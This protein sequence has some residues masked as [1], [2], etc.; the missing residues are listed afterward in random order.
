MDIWCREYRRHFVRDEATAVSRVPG[1][2]L[3][4]GSTGYIGGRL[5]RRL[6]ADGCAVRCLVRRPERLGSQADDTTEMVQGDLL[7]PETLPEAMRG[8]ST[9]YYLVHSMA[10]AGDYA[11]QDRKAA[12]AFSSAAREAGVGRIVYLGGLGSGAKLSGHLRSRQEVGRILRGSGVPTIE[13]RAS[14]IIGSGSLSFEMI[15]S[16]V[17]KLPVMLT[18]RWVHTMSQPIAVEDVIEYLAAALKIP[19]EKSRIVEI[20]GS[21]RASYADI[22]EAYAR[23]RGLR[24][25]MISVPVLSPRLSGLWLGLIT[26]IYARV[27]RKLVESLRNETV[28]DGA[29]AFEMFGIRPRGLVQAIHRALVNEDREF[30]ETRWSDAISSLGGVATRAGA[31]HGTRIVDSR[32]R[33]VPVPAPQAFLPIRRIGGESGWY[34]SDWLWR[35]RGTLDLL[36][37]GP[38]MRRGR[39]NPEHP[40]VGETIDFWRVEAYEE[41]RLLRLVAEMRLPGRAWLQFEVEPDGSGSRVRQTAEFDPRGFLGLAYWYALY[42]LHYFVFDRLLRGIAFLAVRATWET[43]DVEDRRKGTVE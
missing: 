18:P 2:I 40:A 34:G 7:E 41:D 13:F 38:G 26:P 29:Q 4:T 3:L 23:R 16:L 30:A 43:T 33:Y 20:G 25:R 8:I 22:M 31:R 1:K 36:A 35:I 32:V 37:G 17:E 6:E 21:E 39:K 24:R 5:L 14:I 10:S 11:E 27:G 19:L 15:R 9:A 12:K 28:V 42:P